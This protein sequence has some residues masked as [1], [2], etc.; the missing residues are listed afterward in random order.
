MDTFFFKLYYILSVESTQFSD[1][2]CMRDST[3]KATKELTSSCTQV[4]VTL[5]VCEVGA[6][7]RASRGGAG[8]LGSP[9]RAHSGAEAK[10]REGGASERNSHVVIDP[11]QCCSSPHWKGWM[12]PAGTERGKERGLERI[13]GIDLGK[14]EMILI[15]CLSFL[16]SHF[17]N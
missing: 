7:G 4:W 16:F 12:V 14:G 9:W 2:E 3:V 13:S 5:T 8:T 10:F 17:S 15:S 1:A 11:N 6:W